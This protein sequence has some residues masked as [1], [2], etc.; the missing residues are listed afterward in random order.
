MSCLSSTELNL[1]ETPLIMA[2]PAYHV[3]ICDFL[4]VGV[5]PVYNI[6]TYRYIEFLM[7]SCK[8][9]VFLRECEGGG[10]IYPSEPVPVC[11]WKG[12]RPFMPT[13]NLLIRACG[14]TL[15]GN[16]FVIISTKLRFP[17]IQRIL[18][19]SRRLYN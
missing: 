4:N 3:R 14:P 7:I 8:T 9:C 13:R 2:S 16:A 18:I 12:V 10:I 15:L 17:L 6:T 1:L 11:Y 5:I 19:N